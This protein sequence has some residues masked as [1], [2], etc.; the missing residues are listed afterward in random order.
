MIITKEQ[1]AEIKTGKQ[2]VEWVKTHAKEQ[3]CKSR[4]KFNCMYRTQ[5]DK[6]CFV[7]CFITDDEYNIDFEGKSVE[8]LIISLEVMDDRRLKNLTSFLSTHRYLLSRLQF[9]HDNYRV[10]EW[11]AK[12][13]NLVY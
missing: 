12:F 13:E 4:M 11:E 2:V 5:G 6:A 3:G 8:D 9:I 10:D 1:R 7:G